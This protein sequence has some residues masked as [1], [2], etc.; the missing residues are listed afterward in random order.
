MERCQTPVDAADAQVF[1]EMVFELVFT[2]L[3]AS[4]SA[5]VIVG[6]PDEA[7][8]VETLDVCNVLVDYQLQLVW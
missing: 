5:S 2:L 4:V 7:Y 6:A 1:R 3:W 8:C